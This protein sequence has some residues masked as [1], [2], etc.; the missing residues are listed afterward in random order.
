MGTSELGD[1]QDEPWDEE[2]YVPSFN[3][4]LRHDHGIISETESEEEEEDE[5]EVSLEDKDINLGQNI[6]TVQTNEELDNLIGDRPVIVY[7]SLLEKLARAVI[8]NTCK[9]EGCGAQI[10]I[11]MEFVSSAVYLKWTCTNNHVAHRWCSQPILN[12]RVHSGDVLFSAALLASGNNFQKLSLFAKFLKLPILSVSSFTKIQRTYV[13]PTI[14]EIWTK[15]QNEILENFRGSD[16]VLLG[17]G[18]MDSPGHSAQYCTYTFMENETNTILCIIIMDK[19]MTGGKSAV[20]EKACFKKGLQFLLEKGVQVV[21]VVTDAHV[22]IEAL[23]KSDYPNIKHSFDIWH[24]S[25]NLGK[26]I[27]KAGQEK[28]KKAILQWTREVVNHFWYCASKANSEDEF[29]SMWFGVIHHVVNEHEWILPYRTGGK[30]SC[31]HGPLTEEREKGWIVAG[32]PA[33]NALRDIV[34]DTRLLKKIP[35]FLNCRSTATL[36]NFQNLIL[37]YSSKRHSY[38]PPVYNAR[39]LVAAMDH[40]ANCGRELAK[41]KDGSVRHQRCFSKKSVRWSAYPVREGKQYPY[42]SDIM[43][44]CVQ[45]RLQDPIRMNRPVVFDIED[46]RRVSETLAS[47]RPPSTASLVAEKKSRSVLE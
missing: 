43:R 40:N 7:T 5:E 10:Q 34:C 33:H 37:K 36:E 4:S 32:S 47:V 24:G 8:Y 13:I 3:I 17:D 20:L 14:E 15:H 1:E 9:V 46:P 27:I 16:V 39:N 23:M 38:T 42:A 41:R 26:K 21:K 19:R 28:L 6:P 30:S 31:Q 12:R 22:Q 25:K 35:Y 18:R 29:I 44:S 11:K 45:N 2:E